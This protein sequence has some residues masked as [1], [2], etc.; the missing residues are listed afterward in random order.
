MLLFLAFNPLGILM[1]NIKRFNYDYVSTKL[2]GR[3]ILNYQGNK[4]KL[5]LCLLMILM[6]FLL[7]ICFFLLY[8]S[9]GIGQAIVEQHYSLVYQSNSLGSRSL[10]TI[11]VRRPRF[12][13][14]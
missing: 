13:Y 12:T 1:N 9:A 7:L 8:R 5:F 11:I 14:R 10:Q 3:T 6:N 2:D 4:R